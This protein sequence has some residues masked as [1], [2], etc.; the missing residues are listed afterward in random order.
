MLRQTCATLAG[1]NASPV[2]RVKLG[3]LASSFGPNAELGSVPPRSLRTRAGA[4]REQ[5]KRDSSGTYCCRR[6]DR[7][8]EGR[9]AVQLNK[10]A[11]VSGENFS[12]AMMAVCTPVAEHKTFLF[13]SFSGPS[14]WAG[15]V[16]SP[17]QFAT[18]VQNDQV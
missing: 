11:F 1:P 12:H 17:Y 6:S 5:D 10:I 14:P 9:Q 18:A 3:F 15:A 2:D 8:P 4:S 16:C 13:A 7:L